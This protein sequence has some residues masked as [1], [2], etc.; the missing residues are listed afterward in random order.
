MRQ[1]AKPSIGKAY[2]PNRQAVTTQDESVPSPTPR[3]KGYKSPKESNRTAKLGSQAEVATL[4]Q[5]YV[6]PT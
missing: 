3:I 6:N 1:P 5:Q 4:T 2:V